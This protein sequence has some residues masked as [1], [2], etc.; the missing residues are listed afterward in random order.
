[1][2]NENIKQDSGSYGDEDYEYYNDFGYP[3]YVIRFRKDQFVFLINTR[4]AN[5][6]KSESIAIKLANE[7]QK[8]ICEN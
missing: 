3:P 8:N 2:T 1:M 7:F 6:E 5:K 4:T